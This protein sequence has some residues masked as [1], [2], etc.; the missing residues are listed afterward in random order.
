MCSVIAAHLQYGRRPELQGNVKVCTHINTTIC[1]LCRLLM[2]R[3]EGPN[4]ILAA[5]T[6]YMMIFWTCKEWDNDIELWFGRRAFHGLQEPPPSMDVDFRRATIV[7]DNMTAVEALHVEAMVKANCMSDLWLRQ[8]G[9]EKNYFKSSSP[10]AFT[11]W[12]R[13][14]S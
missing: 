4:L 3:H 9:D 7:E 12:R 11:L 14:N 13:I 10:Y 1:S 2:A 6:M 5:S 8:K